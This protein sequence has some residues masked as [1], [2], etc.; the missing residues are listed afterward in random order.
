MFSDKEYRVKSPRNNLSNLASTGVGFNNSNYPSNSNLNIEINDNM[1]HHQD[2]NDIVITN[3]HREKNNYEGVYNY[4]Q[5]DKKSPRNGISSSF[6][7]L[8]GS[9]W[10]INTNNPNPNNQRNVLAN[11]KYDELI[12]S[13]HDSTI[14]NGMG[15]DMGNGNGNGNDYTMVE[16]N[17]NG[18][19]I[20][21]FVENENLNSNNSNNNQRNDYVY[22]RHISPSKGIV[23]SGKL[24]LL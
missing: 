24:N 8:F 5:S 17:S 7:S 20:D 13:N 3:N 6:Y 15:F 1:I 18:I 4:N 22:N 23:V 12:N 16:D 2:S 21:N 10:D 14:K 9:F 11:K 19:Y